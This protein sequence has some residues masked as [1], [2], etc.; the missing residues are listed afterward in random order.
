MV[1]L[2]GDAAAVREP[3]VLAGY[4]ML[5]TRIATGAP[6]AGWKLGAVSRAHQGRY[7][8]LAPVAGVVWA[9]GVRKSGEAVSLAGLRLPGVEPELAVR[10]SA[11]VSRG[12]DRRRLR[13]AMDAVF[14]A[15]EIVEMGERE[16]DLAAL[17]G[18]NF[19]HRGVVTPYSETRSPRSGELVVVERNGLVVWSVPPPEIDELVERLACAA[20]GAASMGCELRPGDMVMTGVI[21]PMPV[22]FGPGDKVTIRLGDETVV[23]VR[24]E[25]IP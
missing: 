14:P 24:G 1:G 7:G 5:A 16:A 3:S 20:D 10:L 22:R 12:S 2:Q 4:Q 21:T 19:S 6:R 15:A 23:E 9:E 18:G 17:V 11:P 13:E 25:E 8:L